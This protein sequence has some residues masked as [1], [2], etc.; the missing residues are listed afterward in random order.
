MYGSEVGQ[1][2]QTAYDSETEQLTQTVYDS[3]VQPAVP[4]QAQTSS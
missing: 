1:R 3:E 4:E 2:T